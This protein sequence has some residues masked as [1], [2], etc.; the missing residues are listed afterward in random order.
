MMSNNRAG[1]VIYDYRWL[2]IKYAGLFGLYALIILTPVVVL[3]GPSKFIEER[4][5]IYLAFAFN[6][7]MYPMTYYVMYEIFRRMKLKIANFVY[8]LPLFFFFGAFMN[9]KLALQLDRP[10]RWLMSVVFVLY[11]G[12]AGWMALRDYRFRKAEAMAEIEAQREDLIEIQAEAIRRA[13]ARERD[14][15]A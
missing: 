1:V 2:I 11:G 9:G 3:T 14:G 10:D 13:A 5:S 4:A 15:R 12:I 8:I 7:I 6:L